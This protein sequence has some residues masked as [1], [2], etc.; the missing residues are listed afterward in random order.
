LGRLELAA[1]FRALAERL[2]TLRL[3]GGVT[4]QRSTAIHGPLRVPVA[5]R[6]R[7]PGTVSTAAEVA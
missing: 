3:A 6:G 4:M 2:P 1:A 7:R 5:A